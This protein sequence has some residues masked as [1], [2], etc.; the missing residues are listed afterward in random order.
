[1]S[2][3]VLDHDEPH[4]EARRNNSDRKAEQIA[5]LQTGP[6]GCPQQCKR[7]HR[8][9]NLGEAAQMIG[10]TVL[11]ESRQPVARGARLVSYFRVFQASD[12]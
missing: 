6:R 5:P 2:T 12:P 4:E 3:I 1:M 8:D 10:R 9:Q 11:I 7:R